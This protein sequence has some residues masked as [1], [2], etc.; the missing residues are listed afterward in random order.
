MFFLCVCVLK[1]TEASERVVPSK[2][3]ESRV[4]GHPAGGDVAAVSDHS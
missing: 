2:T 4:G 3:I 1:E